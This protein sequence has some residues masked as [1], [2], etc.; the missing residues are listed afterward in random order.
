MG[1]TGGKGAKL[2]ILTVAAVLALAGR[3]GAEELLYRHTFSTVAAGASTGMSAHIVYPD[4]G[5]KPKPIARLLVEL[6]VGTRFDEE[7]VPA[8]TA[9]DAEL[10]LLGTGACPPESRVGGGSGTVVTG[11]GPPIDPITGDLHV[12]HAPGQLVNL[13][14][15]PDSDRVLAIARGRIEGSRIVYTPSSD[16]PP[17]APGG[18]PDGRTS[19]KEVILRTEERSSGD[20]GFMTTPA[21]CPKGGAWTFRFTATYEDGTS[22]AATSSSPCRKHRPGGGRRRATP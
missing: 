16:T 13:G 20:R 9:S 21:T 18:P 12:Y 17:I 14:T 3:A 2:A 10:V 7:V 22:D 15:P 8:C 19:S 5:G 11:F 6:P 4:Y 1:P